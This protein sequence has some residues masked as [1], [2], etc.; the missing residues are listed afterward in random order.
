[1]TAVSKNVYFDVFDDIADK[2]NNTKNKPLKLNLQIL[3]L[4]PI[5]NTMLILMIIIINLTLVIMQE[6]QNIKTFLLKDMLQIGQKK[7]LLLVKLKIQFHGLK[8][9]MIL[10][11]KKL[12]ELFMKKIAEDKSK[13]I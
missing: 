6:F 4:I 7:F 5:L 13:R 10:M 3:N 9:L 11:M 2:C 12:L 8:L 1:M